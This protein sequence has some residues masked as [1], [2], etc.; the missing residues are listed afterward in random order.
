[1]IVIDT[2]VAVPGVRRLARI[3]ATLTIVGASIA[4]GVV[5]PAS[6]SE[7]ILVSLDGVTWS[8]SLPHALFVDAAELI[9][10][11]TR[12][13]TVYLKNSSP[14][15]GYLR[16]SVRNVGNVTTDYARA[17]SLKTIARGYPGVSVTVSDAL[18]CLVLINALRLDPGQ[19]VAVTS[20]LRLGDL[21]GK[22][23]QNQHLDL[24]M[25]VSLSEAASL[26]TPSTQCASDVTFLP[27]AGVR[28]GEEA[29]SF[30]TAEPVNG[31]NQ[32]VTDWF[33]FGAV[34]IGGAL[35]WILFLLRR[36]RRGPEEEIAPDGSAPPPE[37]FHFLLDEEQP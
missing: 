3:A 36:R 33:P 6:A 31:I 14:S 11:S 7:E 30:V 25:N 13:T 18:P 2:K 28:D 27:I 12:T 22:V 4:F 1:M 17:L 35:F 20:I 32:L 10:L 24:E 5:A 29:P 37:D 9:P 26:T 16:L 23:G 19:S 34:I 21:V 8:S 15:A